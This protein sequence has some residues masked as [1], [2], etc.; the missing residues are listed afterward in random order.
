LAEGDVE[1]ETWVDFLSIRGGASEWRWWLGP[2]WSPLEGVEIAAFTSVVQPF[3]DPSVSGAAATAQ[4]WAEKL[5]GRWRFASGKFGALTLELDVRIPI[6]SDLPWQISPTLSWAAQVSRLSFV[7]QAGY[8]AG[9]PGYY[10]GDAYHWFV[11]SAGATVEVVKGEVSPLL[12]VGVEGFGEGVI[13]GINDLTDKQSTA[14]LGPVVS[15]AR[16]RLWF[17]LGCLF[18][19]TA[20][21]PKPFVRGVIGLSL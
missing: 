4:L 18:G 11:W 15:M 5:E 21:S 16:G 3:E 19:L 20:D 1:L 17:S 2:R 6:A 8:A 13:A 7:A 9:L 12:Q 10:K 14:N